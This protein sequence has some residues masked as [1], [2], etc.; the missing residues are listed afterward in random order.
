MRFRTLPL[1][2]ALLVPAAAA[3]AQAP[4]P[5]YATAALARLAERLAGDASLPD[6]LRHFT[7]EQL[8]GKDAM[9]ALPLLDDAGVVG[10]MRL[11]GASMHA[12]PEPECASYL[13]AGGQGTDPEQML[14]VLPA[15]LV[16][17]WVGLA[18]ALLRA[19]AGARVVGTRATAEEVRAWNVGLMTR[20][21]AGDRDRLITIAQNPP[22]SQGDAC[23]AIRIIMDDLAA[24]P[25]ATLAPIARAMFGQ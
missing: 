10:V 16:D 24:A 7:G 17:R 11:L 2:A 8:I 4:D 22:P 19:R 23:W 6:S 15:P 9:N 21:A 1:V 18:E 14:P 3:R 13:M 5:A 25:P 20:L 12:L